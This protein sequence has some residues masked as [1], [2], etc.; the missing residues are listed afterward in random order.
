ML[1]D[2][3]SLLV[4]RQDWF[5]ELALEHLEISAIAIAIAI[6]IGGAFGIFISQFSKAAKPTLGVVNVLYTIPSI[7]MLGFLIPFS[8]VGNV[9][10]IIALTIYALL[11]MVRNT[12][13]GITNVDPATVEAAR[14]MGSTEGQILRRIKL[15]LAMPVIMSGIRS[16]VTMTIALA[17]IASFIGAGGLG[18]AIY[19]GITTNDAAMTLA[20]SV[21]IALMALAVD[22]I[23]G[24]VEHR[25]KVRSAAAKR[26]NK[27]I[28][29]AA[30]GA[31]AVAAAAAIMPAL[32]PVQETVK[33]AAKPIVEQY[34]LGNMLEDVIE[35][36]TDLE[37]DL[38]TVGA[39]TSAIHPAM[40]EG[41]FDLY[42]E[43][44]G[45]AWETVLKNDGLY[46][47]HLYADLTSQ[48]DERYDMEW[49][50]M[51]GFENTWG[52][53]VRADVAERYGLRTMSDLK[54]AA[55]DLTFGAEY[56]FFERE[57]GYPALSQT[58]G[59]EF[60]ETMDMEIGL[61]YD[62]LAQGEVDVI[63]VFTTD[64]QLAGVDGVLLEDDLTFFPSYMCG[65]VVR[66][67][68]LEEYPELRTALERLGNTITAGEMSEMN[69]AV[70]VE[71]RA[72]EDVAREFLVEEGI[73][74]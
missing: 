10:A 34:I 11:P 71:G 25:M 72:P 58:Y 27:F 47:E 26:A 8:G 46:G 43:Y 63:T 13:T 66:A 14:A 6:V 22:A 4:E 69:Y 59:F 32:A 64:G 62:A 45:T 39:G 30:A 42:A 16:M 50:G 68:T 61:K 41:E 73:I 17:G 36:D 56:D 60:G 23:L 40:Q 55:P 67:E 74:R 3:W 57:D 33:V 29:V 24:F 9:T 2:V 51:Y 19:R 54:G 65:N 31:A 70:E 5:F 52:L 35:H 7:S 49:V 18:V 53:L 28:A 20:G 37:V 1:Q 12:H 15:P 48:Y 38:T 44:T 21:L